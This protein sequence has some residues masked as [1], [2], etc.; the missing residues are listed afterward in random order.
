MTPI[1]APAAGYPVRVVNEITGQ[2]REVMSSL[3]RED[4][5][6]NLLWMMHGRSEEEEPES[7]LACCFHLLQDALVLRF[8]PTGERA[9]AETEFLALLG[10][11][12]R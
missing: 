5:V 7:A 6:E 3:S 2:T 10:G 9:A 8:Y 12:L 1:D 11:L 4:L